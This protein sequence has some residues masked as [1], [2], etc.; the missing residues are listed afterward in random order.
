MVTDSSVGGGDNLRS[1]RALVLDD[2]P[3]IRALVCAALEENSLETV[4]A[5]TVEA[6]R[7]LLDSESFDLVVLDLNL[8]DGQGL[9]LAGKAKSADPQPVVLVLT[10]TPDEMNVARSL[11]SGVDAYLMKPIEVDRLCA[12][13][14]RLLRRE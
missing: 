1:G 11:K 5:G 4:E 3:L 8:P 12:I 6:A 14:D 10:G 9:D 7:G 2:D 13:V